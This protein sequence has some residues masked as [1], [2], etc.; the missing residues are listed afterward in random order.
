[1]LDSIRMLSARPHPVGYE[2]GCSPGEGC[3][4]GPAWTDDNDME[5]GRNGCDTRNDTLRR[6]L[7][8]VVLKDGTNG[9]VVLSGTFIEPYTGQRVHFVRAETDVQIDH[10]VPLSL[11]WDLGAHAWPAELRVNFA[12]DPRNLLA[13]DGPANQSKGDQGP[14]TWLPVNKDFRCNYAER[15]TRV[16]IA[17]DLPLPVADIESLRL[18]AAAC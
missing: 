14:G 3:V 2:R 18:T 1:M 7:D 17:Y 10:L 12:N 11:A 9:C 6:D 5:F 8:E 13:A 15:F 4:F 16:V